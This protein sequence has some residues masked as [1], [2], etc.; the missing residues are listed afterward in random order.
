MPQTP[1]KN[2][3]STPS[4]SAYCWER[5]LTTACAIVMRA[6]SIRVAICSPFQTRPVLTRQPP[7][8]AIHPLRDIAPGTEPGIEL[9][10]P[11]RS[12]PGI[13]RVV[14]RLHGSHR[15]ISGEDVQVVPG[16]AL[17]H[18]EGVIP[19]RDQQE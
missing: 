7:C 6:V 18:G 11:G 3:C 10:T 14:A 5:N 19:L 9:V 17:S 2:G 8:R 15:F 12:Y 4:R 1:A 13:S 16:V